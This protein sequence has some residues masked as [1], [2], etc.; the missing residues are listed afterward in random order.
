MKKPFPAY[1]GDEPYLFVSYSHRD[2]ELVFPELEK[3]RSSGF[4]IWYDEGIEAGTEWTERIAEAIERSALFLFFVTPDSV[5]SQNCRNEVNFAADRNIDIIAVHLK[6]TRLTSGLS[7]TL[8]TRQAILRYQIP[9]QDYHDKLHSRVAYYLDA[10]GAVSTAAEQPVQEVEAPVDLVKLRSVAVLPFS[11]SSSG[12]AQ[13]DF[14]AEGLFED[15]LDNLAQI[16]NITVASRI[17]SLRFKEADRDREQIGAQLGVVFLLEGTVRQHGDSLRVTVQLTRAADGY[18]VWS[19]SFDRIVSEGLDMQTETATTIA[20]ISNGKL[21]FDVWKSHG[22]K[23]EDGFDGV[24]PVAISHFIDA[25]EEY[26][27]IR[28]GEGGSFETFIRLLRKA[29][30]VDEKFFPA[31]SR[32]ALALYLVHFDGAPFE[33]VEAAMASI[34]RALELN[35]DSAHTHYYATL[36]KLVYDLDYEAASKMFEFYL[37]RIPGHVFAHLSLAQ[38]ALR[39]GRIKDALS[40]LPLAVQNTDRNEQAMFQAMSGEVLFG[41][42]DY[43]GAKRATALGLKHAPTGPDRGYNLRVHSLSLI[44]LGEVEAARPFIEEGWSLDRNTVPEAYICLYALVG[45]EERARKIL[46]N[47]RFELTNHFEV[48][49][50]YMALGET[51]AVFEPIA[52]GI[53]NQCT[54]LLASLNVAEFWDPI[55]EDPRFIALLDELDEKVTHT[56]RY[57]ETARP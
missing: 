10:P 18:H 4:N 37:S 29:I 41:G 52:A 11:F 33:Y 53:K 30:S 27:K 1:T 57:L 5:A 34:N 26:A 50:G 8:A 24:D 2:S 55:R 39:E 43:D 45:E 38:I 6:E 48:A 9:S 17:D 49:R 7:L 40:Q 23:L 36:I 16:R 54:R 20:H 14:F 12:G 46:N 3:L 15:I 31:H 22:W 21:V 19:Q 51:D 13:A 56:Q 32:L 47:P 44:Y 35:P 25:E 42:G 28:L